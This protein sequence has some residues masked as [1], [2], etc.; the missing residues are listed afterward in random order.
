M[1]AL[2]SLETTSKHL[3]Q[4]HS[5]SDSFRSLFMYPQFA[6]N[7]DDGSNLPIFRMF[8][9]YHSALYS[10]IVTKLDQLT[11]VIACANLW[12]CNIPLMFKSSIQILSWFLISSVLTLCR[13]S[14][15]WFATFSWSFANLFFVRFPLCLENLRCT[16][17]NLDSA[18]RKNLGFSKHSPSEVTKKDLIPKSIPTEVFSFIVAFCLLVSPVSQRIDTKYLP[19]GVLLMVACLISPLIGRCKT[20]SIPFL[21]FGIIN[22]PFSKDTFCGILKLP[23]F[24]FFLN[25]GK[26]AC[27]LKKRVKARR[28][29]DEQN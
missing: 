25:F 2:T 17:F 27:P 12:F 7:F 15:R 23:P 11:S 4:I 29:E 5:L 13:K 16:N 26:S 21:N 10:N 3:G 1:A 9:P 19:V 28:V 8:L 24:D 22:L 6:C 20:M 18:F 14:L